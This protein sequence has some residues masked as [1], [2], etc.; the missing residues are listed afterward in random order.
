MVWGRDQKGGGSVLVE[1]KMC[2]EVFL[3]NGKGNKNSVSYRAENQTRGEA[4]KRPGGT[5]WGEGIPSQ[6][7]I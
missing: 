5:M 4:A 1:I 7:N 3:G 6:T 2:W